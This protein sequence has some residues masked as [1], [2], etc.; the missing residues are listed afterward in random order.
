M[1]RIC[2][3]CM[4]ALTL[5]LTGCGASSAVGVPGA[6]ART[7][8]RAPTPPTLRYHATLAPLNASGVNGTA[9]L[10]VT[11]DTM[12][13]TISLTGLAPNQEHM[14]H[15]H[16]AHGVT[17]TCPTPASANSDG[18]ITLA[19]GTPAYGPVAMPFE[20]TP[21]ADSAGRIT[22]SQQ[23]A[24]SPD[25]AFNIVPLTSHVILIHGLTYKG[26]YDQVLPAACGPIRAD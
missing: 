21:F 17:A 16:G 7:P 2:F 26:V 24:I 18:V 4:I 13:V 25:E 5:A 3:V 8:T 10:V 20:P 12:T 1:R 15:I 11:G 6:T 22:W 9:E 14:Q 19:A 23:L